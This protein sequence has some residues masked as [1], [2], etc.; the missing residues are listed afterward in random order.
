VDPRGI[1]HAVGSHGATDGYAIVE[2][3]RGDVVAGERVD[4]IV[5]GG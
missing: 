5:V 3:E 4:V 1:A 2:A